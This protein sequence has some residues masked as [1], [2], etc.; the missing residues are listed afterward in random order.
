M[1]M[2]PFHKW[3]G[4]N[5]AVHG[6]REYRGPEKEFASLPTEFARVG[7]LI[8][9]RKGLWERNLRPE[10]VEFAMQGAVAP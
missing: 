10:K 2:L 5:S 7:K 8:L 6:A 9:R 3:R 1:L 4:S